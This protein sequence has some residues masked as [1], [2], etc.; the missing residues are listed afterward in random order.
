MD[1]SGNATS[2]IY[3]APSV[4]T[5]TNHNP[6]YRIY[7]YNQQFQMLDYHQFIANLTLANQLNKPSWFLEYSASSEYS[8]KDMTPLSFLNLVKRFEADDALFKKWLNNFNTRTGG[9][10]C[11]GACKKGFICGML[12]ATVDLSNACML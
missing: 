5:F 7:E 4:T 11:T 2:V 12:S 3:I 6:A 10:S 8:L 9:G 1:D